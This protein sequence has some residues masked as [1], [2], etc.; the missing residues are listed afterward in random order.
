ML[1]LPE[2]NGDEGY[3]SDDSMPELDGSDGESMPELDGSDES[4]NDDEGVSDSDDEELSDGDD[5]MP[6][7]V[8][9]GEPG[10]A[11][12]GEPG[13]D[14]ES[15]AS[16]PSLV[17]SEES[18][19]DDESASSM[20]PLLESSDDSDSD[21]P[22]GL[23]DFSEDE[24]FGAQRGRQRRR[25]DA[26]VQPV[27]SRGKFYA[28]VIGERST[29]KTHPAALFVLQKEHP[30]RRTH[31]PFHHTLL[32][33]FWAKTFIEPRLLPLLAPLTPLRRATNRAQPGPGTSTQRK[34]KGLQTR[35]ISNSSPSGTR[36]GR[37]R[38]SRGSSS[39]AS[40]GGVACRCASFRAQNAKHIDF[41]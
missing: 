2:V 13:N 36:A 18:G 32:A 5:G 25:L 31:V 20:P 14:D 17:Q 23:E 41:P 27:I 4:S 10:N 29:M 1:N 26:Q 37:W 16:M 28:K 40:K 15:A 30:P 39:P 24:D 34:R 12:A 19:N 6:S 7:L 33:E 8:Q 35:E 22:P 38:A 3:D 9:A 11:Q 21:G